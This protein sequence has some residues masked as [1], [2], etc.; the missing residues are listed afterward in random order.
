VKLFVYDFE[1]V[2][3]IDMA[4]WTIV[5]SYVELSVLEAHLPSSV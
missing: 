4:G 3:L 5:W 2:L 1:S